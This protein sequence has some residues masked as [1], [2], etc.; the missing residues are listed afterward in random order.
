MSHR[1]DSES[2]VEASLQVPDYN[3]QFIPQEDDEETLWDV[4]EILAERA[5]RY[6]VKWAGTDPATGKPWA[7]SWV[8]KHDCTDQLIHDW[9]VKQAKKKKDAATRKCMLSH[10]FT[11]ATSVT[12]SRS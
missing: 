5:N 10:S 7:P 8:P 3:T 1:S 12:I 4:I 2:A 9:K 6:Q 11:H